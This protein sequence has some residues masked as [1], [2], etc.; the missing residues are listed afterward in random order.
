MQSTK[1]RLKG[2]PRE[3]KVVFCF[4][5]SIN[6]L[7][8]GKMRNGSGGRGGNPVDFFFFKDDCNVRILG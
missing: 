3:R 6:K 7:Q 1:P 8:G 2:T 4:F 5:F